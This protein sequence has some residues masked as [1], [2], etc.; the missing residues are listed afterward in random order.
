M[1]PEDVDTRRHELQLLDVREDVEW[2]AGHIDG[3]RHIPLDELAGR[4][5]ELDRV[6]P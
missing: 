2:N 1:D 5:E 4:V 6:E 3:A